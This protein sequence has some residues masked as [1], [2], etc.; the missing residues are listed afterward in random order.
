MKTN[1]FLLLCCM[2]FTTPTLL[3]N[4]DETENEIQLFEL[5]N[6]GI[7]NGNNPLDSN[8]GQEENPPRP[9]D[10]RATITGRTL[11]VSSQNS[12]IATVIV[13]NSIGSIIVNQQFVG[14]SIEQIPSAGDYSIEI[15]SDD[16]ILIGEFS[17]E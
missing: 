10:Y 6:P 3:L 17:V 9:N 2:L 13:R 14:I 8:I 5:T 1:L 11:A 16:L 4:A 12:N 15:Q 7:I